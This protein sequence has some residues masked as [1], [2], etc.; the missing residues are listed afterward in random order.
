MN[1]KQPFCYFAKEIL[2]MNHPMNLIGSGAGFAAKS[3]RGLSYSPF[4]RMKSRGLVHNATI[5]DTSLKY[6]NY[7][8]RQNE[9]SIV[10]HAH[11]AHGP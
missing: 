11:C 8:L 5:A 4:I 2:S 6:Q 1:A 9:S 7:N 10:N 3:A